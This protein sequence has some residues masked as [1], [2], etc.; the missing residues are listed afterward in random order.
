VQRVEDEVR[1]AVPAPHALR[2]S[3]PDV[4]LPVLLDTQRN[5]RRLDV[6]THLVVVVGA[7]NR[8]AVHAAAHDRAQDLVGNRDLPVAVLDVRHR[9]LP[10]VPSRSSYPGVRDYR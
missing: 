3:A 9:I 4:V 2:L 5:R 8:N 10:S 7:R 6:D 1:V